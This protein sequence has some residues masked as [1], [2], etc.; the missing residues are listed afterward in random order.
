VSVAYTAPSPTNVP[1]SVLEPPIGIDGL[2]TIELDATLDELRLRASNVPFSVRDSEGTF[3][4]LHT[5]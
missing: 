4:L 5:V 1:I 2:D 3:R